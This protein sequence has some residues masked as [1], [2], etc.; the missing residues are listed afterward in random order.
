LQ[1][2]SRDLR[3]RLGRRRRRRGHVNAGVIAAVEHVVERRILVGAL[4]LLRRRASLSF[5]VRATVVCPAMMHSS[6]QARQEINRI[7][8]SEL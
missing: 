7:S 5:L 4:H 8:S 1:K 6:G 2:A 3:L